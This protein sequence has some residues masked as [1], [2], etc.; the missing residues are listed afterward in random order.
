MDASSEDIETLIA[1]T[2]ALSW[3]DSSS[4]LETLP[5]E[6][7]TSELLPLVGQ[8][9][10]QKI[11]NNQTMNAA[12]AKAWF[13][14]NPFSFTVL[15]P[16]LFLFKFIEK[17]H[18]TRILNNVWNMNGFLF[19]IQTWYPSATL[20]DPSLS[21]VSFWIQVH[22]LPLHNMTINNAIAIGKELGLLVKVEENRGAAATF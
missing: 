15:G 21:K 1:Q 3:E 12:L 7:V 17:D 8:I 18:I 19:A 9:I 10:S 6:L 4:Q 22:G 14:A 2:A 11:Q 13:F 5:Q 16:N 20:R